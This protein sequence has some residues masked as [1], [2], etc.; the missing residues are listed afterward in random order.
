MQTSPH[1][2]VWSL[3]FG[4]I[5]SHFLE[6]IGLS[7]VIN[8]IDIR[9]LLYRQTKYK[10]VY[11]SCLQNNPSPTAL[12][13]NIFCFQVEIWSVFPGLDC[14]VLYISLTNT[15]QWLLSPIQRC[16]ASMYCCATKEELW[17]NFCDWFW[18]VRF[19]VRNRRLK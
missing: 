4:E 12:G 16:R 15:N 11:H 17:S 14:K 3:V 2:Y 5:I 9:M 13:G 7:C 8:D 10:V 1:K 6:H 19:L 18:K